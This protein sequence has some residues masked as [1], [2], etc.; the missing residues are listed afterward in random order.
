MVL[1]A[2]LPFQGILQI[3]SC[4]F[5][6]IKIPQL[7]APAIASSIKPRSNSH[8]IE[9]VLTPS[10]LESSQRNPVET[11]QRNPAPI[12]A[13]CRY[14]GERDVMAVSITSPRELTSLFRTP[15]D[16]LDWGPTNPPLKPTVSNNS[17]LNRSARSFPPYTQGNADEVSWDDQQNICAFGRLNTRLHE[18]NAELKA[19]SVR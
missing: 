1:K 10:F 17:T 3:Y 9:T 2:G 4:Q 8:S 11:T 12:C 18:V 13:E 5:S 6:P 7:I 19:K 14:D 15:I 16:S